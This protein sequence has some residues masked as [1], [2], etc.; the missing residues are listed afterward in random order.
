MSAESAPRIPDDELRFATSRSSGP[1][2]QNVNKVETRV[3]LMFDV[4]ASSSL[5]DEEKARVREVLG[6]RINREGVLRVSSQRHR[7]QKANRAAA[8]ERF[9]GL[10]EDALVERPSRKRTRVP[11]G[12]KRRRLQDKRRRAELKRQ[13]RPPIDG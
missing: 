8:V 1:G 5:T 7:T 12:V 4:E 6:G 10:I 11:R 13:R 2:G 9:H 3:T